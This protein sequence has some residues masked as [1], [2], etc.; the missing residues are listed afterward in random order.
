[1]RLSLADFPANVPG[2]SPREFFT[3]APT[4]SVSG[5][6]NYPKKLWH[7]AEMIADTTYYLWFPF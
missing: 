1:M 2:W 7:A 4:N 5:P 6:S 3:Q